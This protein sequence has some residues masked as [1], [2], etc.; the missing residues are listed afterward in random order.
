MNVEAVCATLRQDGMDVVR[1]QDAGRFL[2]EFTYFYS[3]WMAQQEG[4]GRSALFLHVPPVEENDE[5][6]MEE[7]R[8]VILGVV[9]CWLMQQQQ[10][11][12]R[13]RSKL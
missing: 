7:I 8:R 9:Q 5:K 12:I 13:L 11:G 10:R 1:S 4:R 6:G 3:L 2:C